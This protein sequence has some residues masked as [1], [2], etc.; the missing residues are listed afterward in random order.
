[1]NANKKIHKKLLGAAIQSSGFG[2]GFRWEVAL[3][4]NKQNENYPFRPNDDKFVWDGDISE[5]SFYRNEIRIGHY[6]ECWIYE[7]GENG[8]LV[9]NVYLTFNTATQASVQTCG[10]RQMIVEVQS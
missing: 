3:C 4:S 7:R 2:R 1:M 5:L 9:D 8:E 6:L 10:S